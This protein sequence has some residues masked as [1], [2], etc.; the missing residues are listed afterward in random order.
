M[1]NLIKSIF[2]IDTNRIEKLET[3]YKDN[4]LIAYIKLNKSEDDI[5]CP[6]C[7]SRLVFN[8]VKDKIIN[9]KVFS[10]RNMKLVY[11]ARRLRCKNCNYSEFEKNPFTIKGF[12]N[13]ILTVNQVMI[14]LHDYRL[15][16]TMIAK[17]NNISANE[18]I[19]YFDS[20]VVI[21]H[22]TL[23]VNL[24]ID[25]IHSDMA[26]RKN[27]SYLCTLTDNDNFKLIDILTSRSKYELS[28]FFEQ[29]SLKEREKVRY[30]TIDMWSPYKE[31]ALKWLPNAVIA[32]DPFHVIEHLS[33]GFTKVRINVMNTKVYGSSSYY[34]LKHWHKLLESDKYKLD[35]EGKYNH[36]FKQ[37]LNYGDILKMLL[38]LDEKLTL[39]YDLKESYRNFNSHST[40]QTAS[41]EL[42]LL[43]DMF[44]KAD[45]KEYE[46]FTNIIITWKNEIVNS[47]IVSDITGNRL[48][49]AKSEAMNRN[50]KANIS[51]SNG[52]A[53]YNRFR[54]RM[55]YCFNDDLFVILT[56]KLTSMKRDLKQKQKEERN[57][58]L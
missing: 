49:N 9:H 45:I 35:G 25:E 19:R 39:A 42:D 23:P 22:I 58:K 27:A 41:D 30:V 26:K 14:D 55:M 3:A 57:K 48:S 6:V 10:D 54:K 28:F 2:N 46:E 15:N 8:G 21:P 31:V 34:L 53:N 11:K 51:I 4:V 24:G 50:I 56:D 52:L 13:S 32:V 1:E 20:Y 43:I 17:K 18:V 33:N 5:F 47:F 36:I 12:N 7:K 38:E 44:K 16:Y 29:Y 40:Y 37:K